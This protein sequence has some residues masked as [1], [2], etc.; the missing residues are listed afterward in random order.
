M[1]SPTSMQVPFENH[2]EDIL[3]GLGEGSSAVFRHHFKQWYLPDQ[4]SI[5]LIVVALADAKFSGAL[6]ILVSSTYSE[7]DLDQL[8][9]T[10]TNDVLNC[11]ASRWRA[12][13][14]DLSRALKLEPVFIAK[15]WGQEIWYSGM[16]ARGMSLVSDGQHGVPLA[17]LIGLMPKSLIGEVAE[18]DESMSPNLLKILDPLPEPVHG[19]LY[20]E[21]H[22]E[23]RE[24][25]V[26]TSIDQQ[27]WPGGV[28]GIRYGFSTQMRERYPDDEAFRSNYLA[29]VS[30]YRKIRG[31][32]DGLIDEMRLRDGI[33]ANAPVSA[34][35]A[36][37]WQRELPGEIRDI[38]ASLRAAM[39]AFTAIK[40]LSHG[41]VVK[42]PLLMPHAL[43]HGVR[44]VEFQTPVYERKI[45]SFAQKV[46]T[47]ASWDTAEAVELMSIGTEAESDIELLEDGPKVKREQIVCFDDFHVQRVTITARTDYILES[48]GSYSLVMVIQGLPTTN[49]Q[50]IA[51]EE[52]VFVPASCGDIKLRNMSL[53]PCVVLISRP[54]KEIRQVLS[55]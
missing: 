21:L 42:V 45:L 23:K 24:V 40:P 50:E 33:D 13:L 20:F 52:A 46:L 3:S 6:K 15:P 8:N 16:E 35:Q 32:I 17:W 18:G 44:T 19:D 27:A 14:V 34:E 53:E 22:E 2:P 12:P 4:P 37:L 31:Q 51:P 47:Q 7:A 38:E 10:I 48:I 43:Q 26:V 39:D 55:V 1:A 30:N 49:G 28:G 11:L 5:D 9:E 25:Y 29:A 41:D 36:K 54:G